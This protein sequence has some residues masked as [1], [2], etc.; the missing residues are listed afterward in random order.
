MIKAIIFDFDGVII[1]SEPLHFKAFQKVL[2]SINIEFTEEEYWTKYL[3]LTD[4]DLFTTIKNDKHL[5][6]D[7]F[8]INRLAE[9][10][11]LTFLKFLQQ[12]PIFFHGIKSVLNDLSHSFLLAIA[13]GALKNEILY[14]LKKL[15]AEDL[16]KFIVSAEEVKEGK[17]NPE[18]YLLTYSKLSSI[19]N[20]L[21]QNQ[22][23]VIEDSIHGI[24][25]AH[26][27]GMKCLA[28]A[29]SYKEEDLSHADSV[30]THISL[31]N[32]KLI[33]NLFP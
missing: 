8:T 31:L 2:H 21:R 23:L 6:W 19:D 10:K 1:D 20:N 5:D 3:A 24:T 15:N 32:T 11:A 30:I 17:P 12:E 13:S 25:A 26:N 28:V 22:C 4:K 27:A 14:A 33:K 29:H 18:I 7:D 9:E 16:F